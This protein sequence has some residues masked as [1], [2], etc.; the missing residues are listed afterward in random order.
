MVILKITAIV[1]LSY[2][3]GSFNT[4]ILYTRRVCKCDVREQGSR[5]AGA[6]NVARVYGAKAGAVALAGD[7]VKTVLCMLI[8]RLLFDYDGVL[9]AAM[10]CTVGH[11]WPVYYGFRGGKGVAV[12]AA[13][14]VLLYPRAFGV[15]LTTF[16][17]LVL[18]THKVSAGSLAGSVM[19]PVSLVIFGVKDPLTLVCAVFVAVVVWVMHRGNIRRLLDG[20]EKEFSFGGKTKKPDADRK[21]KP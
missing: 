4:A 7:F 3:I 15:M 6:T 19:F 8:G 20:T 12:G 2:L 21:E 9:V 14:A 1:V 10:A 18:L 5:N 11:C 17:L 16:L 13:I